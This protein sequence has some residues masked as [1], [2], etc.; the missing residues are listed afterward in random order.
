MLS[1]L[2]KIYV[3]YLI[4]FIFTEISDQVVNRSLL[5]SNRATCHL[6]TSEEVTLA[7]PA[8]FIQYPLP[9]S[10]STLREAGNQLFREGQL[11][12][13]IE[14]FSEALTRLEKGELLTYILFHYF[15]RL[16]SLTSIL[17]RNVS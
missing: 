11:G 5:H 16:M 8:F 14:K 4:L 3:H 2:D 13:A 15:S 9:D 17:P 12:D 6:K 10:I 1:A 7:K